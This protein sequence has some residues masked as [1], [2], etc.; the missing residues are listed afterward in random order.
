MTTYALLNLAV[1]SLLA[2][3]FPTYSQNSMLLEF[4][5]IHYTL[6]KRFYVKSPYAILNFQTGF[7]ASSKF[8]IFPSRPT[9]I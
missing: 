1:V 3:P 2:P 8:L 6:K 7:P 9:L 4:R 5:I